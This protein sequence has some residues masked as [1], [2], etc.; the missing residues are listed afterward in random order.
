MFGSLPWWTMRN[1][2]RAIVY[3]L[4]ATFTTPQAAPLPASLAVDNGGP[5]AVSDAT[6]IFSQS[7]AHSWR[8]VPPPRYRA[9]LHRSSRGMLGGRFSCRYPCEPRRDQGADLC[10]SDGIKRDGL[11]S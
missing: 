4:K 7:A 1:A 10:G 5:L 3:L 8:A 6:G 2:R 11:K 9:S